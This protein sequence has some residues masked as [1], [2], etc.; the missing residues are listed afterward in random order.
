MAEGDPEILSE[1]EAA[2]LWERAAQLQAEAAGRVE[3]PDVR[4]AAIS[5]PGYALTHVRS[6]A[7]EAG[8]GNEFVDAALA[9]LRA[10]R[11]L[12]SVAKENTFARRFLDHPPNTIT[13]RRIVEGT[14]QEVLSAMEAVFPEEPFRLTLADQ[15]GNPLEQGVL[16]F[17][18]SAT[19]SP[20]QQGFALETREAGLRQVFVSL[21]PIAESTSSCEITVH[22]PVTS[23]KAGLGLGMV[24]AR[25]SPEVRASVWAQRS[26]WR[27]GS[28]RSPRSPRPGVSW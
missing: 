23:H 25:R 22:S 14:P 12:P 15:Q 4:D 1:E 16:V 8:I 20:F 11:A 3:A 9:D 28:S 21:R 24:A 27:L 7:L 19:S 18:I 17:D 6:A 2:R 13:V 5:P 10:E 26:A